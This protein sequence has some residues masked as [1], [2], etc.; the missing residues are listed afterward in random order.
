MRKENSEFNTKFISEAGSELKN[1]DY[2]AFVELDKYAC[3][4]IA[5]GIG[6]MANINGAKLAI[7]SVILKFQETPSISKNAIKSYLKEANKEFFKADSKFALKASIT[8]VVSN[9]E[10]IRYGHLGN[11]RFR[12]YRGGLLKQESIDM[13]FANDIIKEDGLSKDL[14]AKHEERNNLY[15]YLGKDKNFKPFISKKIKLMDSDIIALYTR[16]IW[17]NLDQSEINEVFEEATN[18]AEEVLNNIED[19]ILS[20]QPKQLE[21]YTF[22]VIFA[23][24]IFKDPE[25]KRKIKKLIKVS[26]T[27]VVLLLIISLIFYIFYRKRVKRI[28]TLN[29][30]YQNTIEYIQDNNY[31][32]AKEECN[33]AIEV[34]DKLNNKEKVKDLNNYLK[35]IETT[36]LADEALKS[37]NY[38][39]AQQN[40]INAK[41]RARYADNVNEEYVD[42]KL[43]ETKDYLNV[44]DYINLGD[45]LKETGDYEGA[46]K[47][48]L[49]AKNIASNIYFDKGKEKAIQS[50]EKLY[51]DWGKAKEET[52]KEQKD[53]ADKQIT[54]LEIVKQG[55]ESFR[56]SD[57]E[58]ARLYYTSA[59]EK[60]KEMEDLAQVEVLNN[61]LTSIDE[62]IEEN[63]KKIKIAEEHERLAIDLKAEKNL[64]D[65]KK[66]YLFAKKIY[67]ELKK[68]DKVKEMDSLIEL[69]DLEIEEEKKKLEEELKKQEETL[70]EKITE[71]INEATSETSE[72]KI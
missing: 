54:A 71:P 19:L 39:E 7:Q 50:L 13:S 59:I 5:D 26:I 47:K 24:K 23:D 27:I 40:Y 43:K 16:G 36:I 6:N 9:Y 72:S 29:L 3:Y 34:A 44:Y 52:D 68:D 25:R 14:I 61:K 8:V 28:E 60:Y 65:A 18:D 49:E 35:L 22:A 51:E 64:I 42:N 69:L 37:E 15:S 33:K 38:K 48:Y 56:N 45:K 31:I 30:T 11:T 4:V 67:T 41:D 63:K 70:N 57:Y 62:K 32:R 53:K 12:L 20:K 2:F 1:N 21:N 58:G 17:E 10:K 46:E 66:Q 55:D